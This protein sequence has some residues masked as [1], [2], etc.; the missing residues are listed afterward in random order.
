MQI[1]GRDPVANTEAPGLVPRVAHHGHR[2]HALSG[3]L[4]VIVIV[5]VSHM[6]LGVDLS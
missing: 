4:L 1:V 6:K 2:L 5:G 3:V